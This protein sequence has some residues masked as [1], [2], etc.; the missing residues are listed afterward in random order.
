MKSFTLMSLSL[1]SAPCVSTAA[2]PVEEECFPQGS[3]MAH[4][5][6]CVCVIISKI[7]WSTTRL[8]NIP[9]V[10]SPCSYFLRFF[11]LFFQSLLL[12]FCKCH[13]LYLLFFVCWRHNIETIGHRKKKISPTF[14]FGYKMSA[15]G[16][17]P[18]MF[19]LCICNVFT[20]LKLI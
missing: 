16:I 20:T 6:L 13:W 3:H 18:F 10:V 7:I 12:R 8:H 2:S 5:P 1:I 19:L 14:F 15:S 17:F 9:I 4:S 11:L